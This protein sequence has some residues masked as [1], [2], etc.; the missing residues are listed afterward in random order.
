[1]P[2]NPYKAKKTVSTHSRLKAAG[3]QFYKQQYC[4]Q[5]STHSRLKAAG[6]SLYWTTNSVSV[7][8][9]SRLKAAGISSISGVL[10]LLLFQHTAA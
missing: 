1:M 4:N 2:F 7:S 5:V 10:I 6:S 8:T 3:P 9:H